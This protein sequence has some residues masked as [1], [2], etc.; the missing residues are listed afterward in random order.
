MKKFIDCLLCKKRVYFKDYKAKH[1]AEGYF[2]IRWWAVKKYCSYNC[3]MVSVAKRNKGAY[4]LKKSEHN[5]KVIK[6]NEILK[7][8]IVYAQ[9]LQKH[10]NPD[11]I[12]GDDYIELE[13]FNQYDKLS[14]GKGFLP[15]GK[16]YVLYL[17][18]SDKTKELFDEIHLI[19]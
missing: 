19:E 6:L 13:L 9:C 1:E 10:T 3:L 17:S 8:K 7:G 2:N 12:K 5:D 18:I 16:R 15:K 11:I 14:K 4:K